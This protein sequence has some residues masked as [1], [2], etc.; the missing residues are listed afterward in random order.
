MQSFTHAVLR[1]APFLSILSIL[2]F[3]SHMQSF[4]L[5]VL[6]FVV[7][8]HPASPFFMFFIVFMVKKPR[9]IEKG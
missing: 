5:R 8:I 1:A 9:E 4:F 6:Y 2:W 3:P 7:L